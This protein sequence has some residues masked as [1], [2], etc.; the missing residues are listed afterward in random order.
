VLNLTHRDSDAEPQPLEPGR[1]Y[2]VTV[3]LNVCAKRFVEGSRIRIA[4]STAYWPVVFPAP[5]KVT[6]TLRTGA[7]RLVLPV[8][9]PCI[10]DLDLPAFQRPESAEPMRQIS[11]RKGFFS[12]KVIHDHATGEVVFERVSDSGQVRHEHTSIECDIT[13][14]DRFSIRADDPNSAMT[15]AEWSKTYVRGDW[16]ARVVTVAT[17]RALRDVFRIQATLSAYDGDELFF[18]R[19]W[20]EDVARDLV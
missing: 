10:S 4:L 5:E 12:R 11:L 18:E 9:A 7:S 2:P 1:F 8:R 15:S 13:T 17:V 19:S 14:T 20:D 16:R 3:K 6:L